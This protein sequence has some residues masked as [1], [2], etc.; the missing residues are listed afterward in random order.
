MYAIASTEPLDV[1]QSNECSQL[2]LTGLRFCRLFNEI[3]RLRAENK[4]LR[5]F[6]TGIQSSATIA[7]MD[8]GDGPPGDGD[9]RPANQVAL[10]PLDSDSAGG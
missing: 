1:I 8:V 3:E 7:L 4:T 5:N 10:Y 6:L 2:D 9:A